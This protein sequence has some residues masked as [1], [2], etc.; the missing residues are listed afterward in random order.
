MNTTGIVGQSQLLRMMD[1]IL[2]GGRIAHAYIFAGPRGAG[3][4]TLSS[5]FVKAMLCRTP[6]DKPCHACKPCKQFDSGNHPDV[7]RIRRPEDKKIIPVDLIRAMREDIIIKPFQNGKKIV[8]IDEA[9]KMTEEAQNALL[10]T[11]E[12]PPA[13]ACIILLAENTNALLPTIL[14]RC[15]LFKVRSLPVQDAAK[16]VMQRLNLPAQEARVYAAL[17][18]GIPGIALELAGDDEFREQ[19]DRLLAGLESS[20]IPGLL[21]LAPVFAQRRESV[22]S[23]LDMMELWFRDLLVLKETGDES[24]VV[25]ADK[26]G[27]LRRQSG[28]YTSKGLMDMI[29]S[30]ERCVRSLNNYGNFEL[31]ID[32]MLIGFKEG[33]H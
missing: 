18:R 4:N 29:H 26:L 6:G 25:N 31:A 28:R 12:E 16:I 3:K 21:E 19:R 32:N 9:D 24:L 23:L 15:Q 8:F 5:L 20:G 10:K 13:H 7:S 1:S 17:A 33:V 27:L 11:L 30:V 22:F 2:S 14:S